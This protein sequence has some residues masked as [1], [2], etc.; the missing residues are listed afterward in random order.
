[1]P[2]AGGRANTFAVPI[3]DAMAEFGIDTPQRMSA[4]VSQLAHESGS[5]LYT[6]EIADGSA[7]EG[8]VDL[9]NTEPGDGKLFRGRG[10]IQITGRANTLACLRALGRSTDELVYLEQTVGASRS[11]A[12]F[13]STRG[14]NVFAD[15]DEY[16]ALTRR[17][18]G[19]FNGLDDRIKY[20]LRARKV[21]G[22]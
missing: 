18:N 3:T 8:R 20:W 19:G 2:R 15:A 22:L 11:A 17:I 21:F 16:G 13:W 7:Y 12:W 10:L 4:F 6:R 14:L 9:G 5:L 1:M